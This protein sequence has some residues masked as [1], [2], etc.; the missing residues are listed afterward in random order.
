MKGDTWWGIVSGHSNA[1]ICGKTDQGIVV[2]SYNGRNWIRR[3]ADPPGRPA[4]SSPS[5]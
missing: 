5:R 1:L 3:R 2:E 4:S